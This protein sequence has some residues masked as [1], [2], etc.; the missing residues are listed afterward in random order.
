MKTNR[1]SYIVAVLFLAA[2]SLACGI[3]LGNTQPTPIPPT[4]APP[5]TLA[6]PTQAPPPTAES[7]PVPVNPPAD[8]GKFNELIQTFADKG[9]I[10]ST[11]G[12]I[13]PIDPFKE[14]WAQIGWYQWWNLDIDAGN[15][16]FSSHFKWSTSSS[17]PDIS[18]CGVVFGLQEND[19]HYVVFLDKGRI[20][21]MMKRGSNTYEVGKTRG[22]GQVNFGNSAE[23]DFALAV[24]GSSAYVSVNGEVT[25]YTLSADQ[26]SA[27]GVG[28]TVLSGTNSGYGTRCEMTDTYLFIAK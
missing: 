23:A 9:Y 24:K 26:T 14:E 3:D 4:I 25:E 27:G 15:M 2:A 12:D 21:F 6:P 13:I 22:P 1:L 28:L 11:E 19:D 10:N 5:P 20:A 18:G 8:T 17:T 7:S 16:V